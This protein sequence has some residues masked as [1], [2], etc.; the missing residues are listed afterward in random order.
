[1]KIF[2]TVTTQKVKAL[3]CDGCGLEAKA[4]DYEFHEF[5]SINH[6]CGYS[7]IHGDGKQLDIDLCQQCFADMCGDALSA[8]SHASRSPN[9]I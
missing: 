6:R 8:Y 4:N 2:K 7:S 5:I 3:V 9:T 1:M